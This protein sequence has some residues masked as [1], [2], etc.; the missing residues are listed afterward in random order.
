MSYQPRYQCVY[1]I[2]GQLSHAIIPV[3]TAGMTRLAGNI[4]IVFLEQIT[5]KNFNYIALNV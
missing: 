2:F 1:P 3:G 5:F 4:K